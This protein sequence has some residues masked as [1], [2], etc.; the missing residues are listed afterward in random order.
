MRPGQ[1]TPENSVGR[2]RIAIRI[3]DFNE[4]GAINPGKPIKRLQSSIGALLTSMRPGQLTPE[5]A[6]EEY[7]QAVE[8]LTLQ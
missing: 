1:L 2:S 5:N 7:S 4:A 6:P 8:G 3:P